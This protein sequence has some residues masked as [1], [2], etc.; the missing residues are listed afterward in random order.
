LS[1]KF[2]AYIKDGSEYTFYEC[3]PCL[4]KCNGNKY[5]YY[6]SYEFKCWKDGYPEE[7]K[8]NEINSPDSFPY[9]DLLTLRICIKKCSQSFPKYDEESYTIF[10]SDCGDKFYTIDDP[11]T[12]INKGCN[13]SY[14]LA[15]ENNTKLCLKEC[16]FDKFIL[17][18][19]D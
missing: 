12:C 4:D 6:N 11:N 5:N 19:N 8:S 1:S 16:K 3:L 2:C 17:V 9:E 18:K 13:E 15:S 14:P 10:K 7:Y